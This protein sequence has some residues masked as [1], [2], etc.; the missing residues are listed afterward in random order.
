MANV[1]YLYEKDQGIGPKFIGTLYRTGYDDYEFVYGENATY[2]IR[3]MI[4]RMP[5]RNEPYKKDVIDKVLMDSVS[6][7][8]G[9]K[10]HEVMCRQDG[11]PIDT[12]RWEFLDKHWDFMH[13]LK[14]GTRAPLD[15]SMGN[16]NF[17]KEKV[18]YGRE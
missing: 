6:P 16:V 10:L 17:Y 4:E 1:Y 11:I 9:T 12:C 13:K 2:E 3:T 8:R 15:T 5:I 14:P 18:S 7:P